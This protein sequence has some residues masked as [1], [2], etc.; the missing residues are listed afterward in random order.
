MLRSAEDFLLFRKSIKSVRQECEALF[1]GAF[2]VSVHECLCLSVHMGA[3]AAM[4]EEAM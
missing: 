1:I 4:E 3:G 2:I